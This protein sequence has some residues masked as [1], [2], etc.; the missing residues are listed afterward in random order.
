MREEWQGFYRHGWWRRRTFLDDL[1]DAAAAH[2]GKPAVVGHRADGKGRVVG[3][4]ELAGGRPLAGALVELGVVRARSSRA[5]PHW[6]SC[7]AAA[8]RAAPGSRSAGLPFT[9]A[10]TGHSGP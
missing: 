9:S 7:G 3:Y 4:G 5:A 10:A 1:G 6:W 2:P 8:G